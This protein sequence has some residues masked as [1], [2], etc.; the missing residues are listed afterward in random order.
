MHSILDYYHAEQ[1][2]NTPLQ[3]R[4]LAP[5]MTHL[6]CCNMLLI[7]QAECVVQ[8]GCKI[9][10]MK[11]PGK[12]HNHFSLNIGSENTCKTK[13][14]TSFVCT[15]VSLA[16][17]I[18]ESLVMHSILILSYMLVITAKVGSVPILEQYYDWFNDLCKICNIH[19][20]IAISLHKNTE[21]IHHVLINYV[22]CSLL[23]HRL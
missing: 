18:I 12:L 9:M 11:M 3:Y 23:K 19:I 13:R 17:S 4:S 14:K 20:K 21:H 1:P 8:P 7:F 15:F 2:I 16:N 6:Y 10:F 22:Y 5:H